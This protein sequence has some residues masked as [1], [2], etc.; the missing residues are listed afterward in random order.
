MEKTYD[1]LVLM[2]EE[3]VAE[4]IIEKMTESELLKAIQDSSQWYHS[5]N[6]VLELLNERLKIIE[7]KNDLTVE[8]IYKVIGYKMNL[9]VRYDCLKYR[10]GEWQGMLN[11]EYNYIPK[12]ILSLVP[13]RYRDNIRK[14]EL[15]IWL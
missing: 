8:Q 11:F 4:Q 13:S 10:D 5:A 6:K 14:L 9:I 15:T 7:P 1:Y 3:S 2:E 12:F